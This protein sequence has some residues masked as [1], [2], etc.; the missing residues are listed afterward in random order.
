MSIQLYIYLF[1]ITVKDTHR[2]KHKNIS[3]SKIYKK[4]LKA[5]NKNFLFYKQLK[6]KHWER[7]NK[8]MKE[9]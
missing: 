2:N 3:G 8:L 9:C 4:S 7:G 6:K 5:K 1:N